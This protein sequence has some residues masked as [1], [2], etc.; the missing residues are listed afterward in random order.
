MIGGGGFFYE[1]HAKKAKIAFL[2]A[3][4]TQETIYERKYVLLNSKIP[5][6]TLH[7]GAPK[8]V[9]S[10]FVKSFCL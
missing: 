3:L 2:K 5:S 10:I 1:E 4:N 8:I 7:G 9:S 6:G